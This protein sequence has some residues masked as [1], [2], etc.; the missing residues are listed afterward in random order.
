M[1]LSALCVFIFH[2]NTFLQKKIFTIINEQFLES[3]INT[4]LK[5]RFNILVTAVQNP[6]K[7]SVLFRALND[8][9]LTQESN[10]YQRFIIDLIKHQKF[11]YI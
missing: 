5:I 7:L 2:N 8:L 10:K 3:K 9:G 1:S 11:H 4:S 6:Q